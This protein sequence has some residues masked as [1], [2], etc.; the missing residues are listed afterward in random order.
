MAVRFGAE[1]SPA[2]PLPE[3]GVITVFVTLPNTKIEFIQPLGEASPIAK[4]VE[5][6]ADGGIHHI[7]YDVPDII[8]ARDTLIK[9]GARVLGDG[10]P[11]I[12]AHGKPVL[13]FH[14]KDFSGAL[15]ES[16]RPEPWPTASVRT[17]VLPAV[18]LP[19]LARTGWRAVRIRQADHQKDRTAV[20]GADGQACSISTSAP[21]KSWGEKQHR[22]CVGADLG[23][24]SPSTRAPS[25]IRVSRAAMISGTSLADVMDA[26]VGKLRS[27]T[28]LAI[29]EGLAERLDELDLGVG[30]RHEHRDHAVLRQRHCGRDF[31]AERTAID[32]GRL[33][34]VLDRDRDMIERRP[35]IVASPLI[36]CAANRQHVHEANRLLAHCSFSAARTARR[37]DSA[38]RPHR[39]ARPRQ[40]FTVDTT[41]IEHDVVERLAGGILLGM[42][43]RSTS[44]SSASSPF[45]GHGDGDKAQP[46]NPMRRV[47]YG[48]R[49]GILQDVAVLVEPARRQ[50]ADDAGVAGPELDQIAMRQ[51]ST[52]AHPSARQLGMF[53]QMQRFPCTG[54]SSC[55]RTQEIMSRN[56]SRRGDRKHAPDRA[57]GDDVN[58]WLTRPLMMAPT[59]FSLPGIGAGR[60][61]HAC[62]PCS[63]SPA[64]G[65]HWRCAQ[66]RARLALASRAQRQHLVRR[67]WP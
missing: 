60:K 21:E 26:A 61:D 41:N 62:H 66:R 30:Q 48:A 47:H 42:P 6:N 3:H 25:L 54:I 2:V 23:T 24:P 18:S 57:V 17:R 64:D 22:L 9:E 56:S 58:A 15:V 4:F 37:T 20:R 14:P 7:C 46:A 43:T 40:A 55:G 35:S 67:K 53:R 8:A 1:I 28:N 51:I 27:G 49:L 29:G 59:A 39:A 34:G 44:G 13:F 33:L 52:F 19:R 5:R 63:A 36:P 50:F 65:R 11:K 38:S 45:F 12:G 16:N 32:P 31:G 10:V